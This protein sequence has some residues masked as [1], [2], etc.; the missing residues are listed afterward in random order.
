MCVDDTRDKGLPYCEAMTVYV[1]IA[2]HKSNSFLAWFYLRA[3]QVHIFVCS[4][5]DYHKLQMVILGVAGVSAG[6]VSALSLRLANCTRTSG[7]KH[8]EN[9]IFSKKS[10]VLKMYCKQYPC[11]KKTY[12]R[13]LQLYLS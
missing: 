13:T 7:I 4:T 6:V 10:V 11:V 8:K 12:Y 1:I 9:I 3:Q 5:V 2:C